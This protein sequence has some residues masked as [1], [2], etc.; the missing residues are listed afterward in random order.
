MTLVKKLLLILKFSYFLQYRQ[1]LF[2]QSFM[3]MLLLISLN[4]WQILWNEKNSWF[5][6]SPSLMNWEICT[7]GLHWPQFCSQF[8]AQIHA[9]ENWGIKR[10]I[11]FLLR[12]KNY[13]AKNIRL[14][15]PQALDSL[16]TPRVALERCSNGL[17]GH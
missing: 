11:L 9:H 6:L 7:I 3:N 12:K 14:L 1:P 13:L 10:A 8:K 16:K 15:W 4:I 17:N 5:W 2:V